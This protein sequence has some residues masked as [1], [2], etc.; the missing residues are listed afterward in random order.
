MVPRRSRHTPACGQR[1]GRGTTGDSPSRKNAQEAR[2][3]G[4]KYPPIPVDLLSAGKVALPL[5]ISSVRFVSRFFSGTTI[6]IREGRATC[7]KGK[8]SGS[9]LKDIGTLADEAGIRDGEIWIDKIQRITFS[10]GI[11]RELHQ[12]FRN[13]IGGTG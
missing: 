6:L 2:F 7:V 9:L 13:A 1:V 11:P 8:I 5:H 3:R 12:R 4:L 10:D